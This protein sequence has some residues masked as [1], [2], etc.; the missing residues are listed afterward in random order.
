MDAKRIYALNQFVASGLR[1][2]IPSLVLALCGC[3]TTGIEDPGSRSPPKVW[4]DQMLEYDA[5]KAIKAS[6]PRFES[7][8]LVIVSFNGLVLLVGEVESDELKAKAGEVVNTFKAVRSVHN[9][10]AVS[11]PISM[12]AR[13]NDSWLTTKVKTKLVAHG[14][15]D[16]SRIN[17]T[18]ENS[19]V[20]LQ[21]IVPRQQAEYAVAVTQTVDGVTKIVKVFEYTD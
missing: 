7:A 18:T 20:Y 17:V 14:A 9:E 10:L 8:H 12:V 4:E 6:D 19:V 11:G 16:S 13:S 21:G 1:A 3:A 15:I 2:F 5:E